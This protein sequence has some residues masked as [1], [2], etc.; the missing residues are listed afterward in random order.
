MMSTILRSGGL[1]RITILPSTAYSYFVS[2]G[3]R[4]LMPAGIACN[5]SETGTVASSA[6][7][8]PGGAIASGAL[9]ASAA[10]VACQIMVSWAPVR[11]RSSDGRK[12][13]PSSA[14]NTRPLLQ[15][16]KAAAIPLRR[17]HLIL[18]SQND[19]AS[20]NQPQSHALVALKIGHL[21]LREKSI[22]RALRAG[23]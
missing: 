9:G 1:T 18:A 10:A 15:S 23:R 5:G 7:V 20:A 8:N 2:E 4:S 3:N 17:C 16:S 6:T 14:A 22:R 21:R 12:A 11:A 13:S 19:Q